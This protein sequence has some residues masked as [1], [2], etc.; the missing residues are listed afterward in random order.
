MELEYV[1]GSK[2]TLEIMK[3]KAAFVPF[4]EKI[5]DFLDEM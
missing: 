2:E 5:I 3:K 1:L 4:H